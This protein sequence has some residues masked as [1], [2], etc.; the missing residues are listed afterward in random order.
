MTG[1]HLVDVVLF[2]AAALL[3][4]GLALEIAYIIIKTI[5]SIKKE[6]I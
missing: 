5:Y 3:T 1:A 4:L 2:L 6:R